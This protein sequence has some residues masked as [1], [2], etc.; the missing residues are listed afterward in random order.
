MKKWALALTVAF[1]ALVSL[2]AGAVA[3]TDDDADNSDPIARDAGGGG[4][5]ESGGDSATGDDGG[6]AGICL[7]GAVDCVDTPVED[8]AGD[9]CILISPPPPECAD[10]DAPVTNE[11]APP[12]GS[13]DPGAAPSDPGQACTTEFPNECTATDAAVADLA[14]RLDLIEGTITVI[15]IERVDWPD[16]CLGVSQPDIACAEVITPG[17]RIFLETNAQKYEYHTDGGSHAVLVE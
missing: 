12:G 17:Y 3:L 2:A 4:A 15:S 8:P 7:E 5:G 16:A 10:P 14:A 11:P 6:A 1:L 13:S 9:D